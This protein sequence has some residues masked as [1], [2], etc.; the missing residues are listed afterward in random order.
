[1]VQSC[2]RFDLACGL[3]QQFFDDRAVFNNDDGAR[4]GSPEHLIWIDADLDV[5]IDALAA[6][7]DDLKA[8]AAARLAPKPASKRKTAARTRSKA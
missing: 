2:H 5:L 3:R 8:L 4:A 1:M 6:E 7:Y